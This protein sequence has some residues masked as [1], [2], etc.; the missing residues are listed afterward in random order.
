VRKRGA[1]VV[2]DSL[3]AEKVDTV[4]GIP[5]GSTLL[6]YDELARRKDAIR[7]VLTTHEQHAAHAADGYA[8]SSGRSGVCIAT[9]GP[10][11]TNLLTGVAAAHMDSS[12]VVFLTGNVDRA[13][14]GRDSFQE[15]DIGSVAMP[16][17]KYSGM[18]KD[19]GALVGT[20]RGAF[21]LA[22]SGRPGAVLVDVPR[23]V[24]AARVPAPR[25]EADRSAAAQWRRSAPEPDA[26]DLA[27]VL[28]LL[29]ES[30]RPLILCGGGAIRSNAS[31]PLVA[32][33]ERLGAPVACTMMGLGA[34][35]CDHPLFLGMAGMHGAAA[36][37]QAIGGVR[38]AARGGDAL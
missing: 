23:D 12:P 9:S 10:G 13:L 5:G 38:F 16:I 19:A 4:F 6:L 17:T 29:G 1:A 22:A 24:L 15:V 34:I 28:R 35:P 18:V 32:L 33:A 11:A 25:D 36:A 37:N 31:E 27:Q 3:I 7:H 2:I 21:A 14:I 20:V 26:G 30:R 8:R